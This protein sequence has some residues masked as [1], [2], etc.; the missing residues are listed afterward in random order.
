[1]L[2][3]YVFSAKVGLFR[4]IRHGRRWRSLLD[5]H[6]V[7]RHDSAE[8]ALASLCDTW[9]HAR[10]PQRLDAWRFVPEMALAHSRASGDDVVRWGMAG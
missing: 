5:G 6:E 4:I 10:L 2:A 1:M 3:Q 7:D 8:S 9:P